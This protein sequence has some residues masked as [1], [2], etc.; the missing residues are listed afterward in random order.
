MFKCRATI[1]KMFWTN[2]IVPIVFSRVIIKPLSSHKIQPLFKSTIYFWQLKNRIS[3]FF[4]LSDVQPTAIQ[5]LLG[6]FLQSLALTTLFFALLWLSRKSR[7]ICTPFYS[8]T[9]ECISNH[10]S[11]LTEIGSIS[12]TLVTKPWKKG[13]LSKWIASRFSQGR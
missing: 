11:F 12:T 7:E 3:L 9:K 13:N 8:F 1:Y 2:N 10:N 6:T 4:L 5:C